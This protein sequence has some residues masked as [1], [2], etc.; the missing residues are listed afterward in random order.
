L[1]LLGEPVAAAYLAYLILGEA[2]PALRWSSAV[3]VLAGIALAFYRPKPTLR[4]I[5]KI[6]KIQG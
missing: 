5:S 6:D 4:G 2:L 1:S 3:V